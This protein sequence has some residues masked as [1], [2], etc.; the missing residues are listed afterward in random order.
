MTIADQAGNL[1]FTPPT[2]SSW[3]QH[4][5]KQYTKSPTK[6][7]AVPQML[8]T[9]KLVSNT[10]RPALSATTYD[11]FSRPNASRAQVYLT[12]LRAGHQWDLRS[13]LNKMDDSISPLY[14][15]YNSQNDITLHLFEC[16]GIMAARLQIVGNVD[17]PPCALSTHPHQSITLAQRSLAESI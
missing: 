10:T 6:L 3:S 13:F 4:K 1:G 9:T 15:R 17:V 11:P 7:N 2:S 12:R 8:Y 5:T 16:P 14:P